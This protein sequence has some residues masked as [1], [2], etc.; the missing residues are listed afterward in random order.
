MGPQ[1]AGV[2][3]R[4]VGAR[5]ASAGLTLEVLSSIAHELRTPLSAL[6]A[7]AEMLDL[8]EGD[9]A[10][11]FTAIIQ[12]QALRLSTI[13]DGLL[14]AYRAS[15]GELRH[16]RRLVDMK[17]LLDG[18]SVEYQVLYPQHRFLVEAKPGLQMA[19][20]DRMLSMIV[21]NLVSNAAKY[22]PAGSA[23]R[24]M[25]D[26]AGGRMCVRV[27]DEGPGVPDFLRWRVF[28]AGD[29]GLLTDDAGCGLGL[30]IARQLCDAIGADIALD[31][32]D[33]AG[34]GCFVVTLGE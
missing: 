3:A 24:I 10:R 1:A 15:H 25:A 19:V 26:S 13:V 4:P 29:R 32:A 6:T 30:F 21:G 23:V 8:A 27:Y 20:D 7:S 22:S 17:E 9:D 2:A 11:R 18:L 34:G 31:D 33:G 14:E 16:V 5:S 28:R 12:R